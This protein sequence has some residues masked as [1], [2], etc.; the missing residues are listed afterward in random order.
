MN[1]PIGID[2]GTTNSVMA[3]CAHP[4]VASIVKNA[5]GESITP[6]VVAFDAAAGPIVGTRAV[7]SLGFGFAPGAELFK[8]E[9]GQADVIVEFDGTAYTPEMLSALVLKELA[10]DAA[11]TLDVRPT[12]AVITVPA[13]FGTPERKATQEAARLAGLEC[14]LLIN[15][16][17]AAAIT[18]HLDD[19]NRAGSFLVYDLGGGTFDVSILETGDVSSVIATRGDPRLGGADWDQKLVEIFLE[20]IEDA[21]DPDAFSDPVFMAMVR[22]EAEITKKR[23]SFFDSASVSIIHDGRP[24]EFEVTRAAFEAA[25]QGLVKRTLDLTVE[26][27]ESQNIAPADVANVLLVGGSTRMPMIET[28]LTDYFGCPPQKSLNPDEAVA[29]GA[30]LKADAL[31][32]ETGRGSIT[33]AINDITNHTLGVIAISE[34]GQ[35][36]V[37]RFMIPRGSSL[38]SEGIQRFRH[39]FRQGVDNQMELFVTQGESGNPQEVGYLGVYRLDALPGASNGE[40][41]E[42]E[43]GYSYNASGIGNARAR[44]AGDRDWTD[45]TKSEIG[46]DIPARFAAKPVGDTAPFTVMLVFDVSGSMTNSITD[47]RSAAKNF[48]AQ[49]KGVQSKIGIG[50]VADKSV[51]LLE[52]TEDGHAVHEAIERIE[53]NAEGAGFG[54]A[55]HPFDDLHRLLPGSEGPCTAIV[56]ADGVWSDQSLAESQAKRCRDNGIEI[57]AIGFGHADEHFLD[58]ISSARELSLKVSQS[59]LV[60]AFGSIA[61][62]ISERSGLV[63]PR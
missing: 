29:L 4:G 19:D 23:I 49:L 6:S 43:I 58:N 16:P 24:I 40:Y 52:P 51:V 15:E 1:K 48:V 32:E 55:A 39:V 20:H 13:Y 5:N 56:L 59:D 60:S 30:A 8:R 35:T 9:M 44:L 53:V 22:R 14:L 62:I 54:N 18:H 41:S 34:D 37:N 17:T 28:A 47:T 36:Y 45:M 21:L 11:G 57:V 61:Q 33:A 31:T 38:P 27:L 10:D 50:I 42:I 12:Q 25:C 26:A 63:A 2:L 7:Q 46:D 3:Y